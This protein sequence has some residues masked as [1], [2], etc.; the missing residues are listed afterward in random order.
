[1]LVRLNVR[2]APKATLCHPEAARRYGPTTDVRPRA[3]N[4]AR[5][6]SLLHNYRRANLSTIVQ[7]DDVIVGQTNAA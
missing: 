1:M 4:A 7:V 3:N 6:T 2:S 5:G